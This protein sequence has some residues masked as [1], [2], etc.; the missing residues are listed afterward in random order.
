MTQL[1][2]CDWLSYSALMTLSDE[3]RATEP[4]L[5][6]PPGYSLIEYP[7]TNMYK[8]RAILYDGNG[9]KV[10][11]L[12]WMPHSRIIDGNSLFVE[13]ANPLLYSGQYRATP[14]LLQ[15]I[16]PCTWQSLSRLDIATDFQPSLQ[17]WQVIEMLNSGSVYVQ[18]KQDGGQFHNWNLA[19]KY[20]KR[21]PRELTWGSKASQVRWKLYNKTGEIWQ[22][23]TDGR[24]WCTKPY[25]AE[26]WRINGLDTDRD[27]WR[28]EVSI[29]SSGQLQWRGHRLNWETAADPEA[30]TG[31]YYDLY[32]TRMVM[33][34][35]EGHANKRYDHTVEFLTAPDGDINRISKS[36]PAKEL[37]KVAYAPTIRQLVRELERPEVE[38]NPAIHTPLLHTLF[39]IVNTAGLRGYFAAMVGTDITA[40]L[41]MYNEKNSGLHPQPADQNN[42][43]SKVKE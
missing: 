7:G 18:G 24:K 3:E 28:L 16:H 19:E 22:Q 6:E 40:W 8:K 29:M 10:M 37:T 41:Q 30:L 27:T 14:E 4:H 17:Q 15:Q 26:W 1:T 23:G 12:L 35:N 2:T 39:T 13:V 43:E 20:V 31:L 5:T 38:I 42:E 34:L 36:A 11:T 25:I 9:E 33:R 32:K 21:T